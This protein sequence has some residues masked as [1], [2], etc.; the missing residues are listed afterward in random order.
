[1]L[2]QMVNPISNRDKKK[3]YQN[4]FIKFEYDFLVPVKFNS[5]QVLFQF[6]LKYCIIMH[7]KLE[8]N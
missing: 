6:I 4:E 1:M 5:M 7:K 2:K 8:L 3:L